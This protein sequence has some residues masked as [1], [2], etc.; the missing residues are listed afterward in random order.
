MGRPRLD[1]SEAPL[2]FIAVLKSTVPTAVVGNICKACDWRPQCNDK[3]TDFTAPGHRCM[4]YPVVTDAGV[5]V[6]RAD[7]CSVVFKRAPHP[8]NVNA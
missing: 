6:H 1:P 3:A 2:G 5:E 8:V 7:G 4:G